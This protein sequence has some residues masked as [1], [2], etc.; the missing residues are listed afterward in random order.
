MIKVS[1]QIGTVVETTI[2]AV[3]TSAPP[4]FKPL[5]LSWRKEG[6]RQDARRA[7][8]RRQSA[9]Y[10]LG[11]ANSR[12]GKDGA[13]FA[14]VSE[15][16]TTHRQGAVQLD[17]NHRSQIALAGF[18]FHLGR[19]RGRPAFDRRRLLVRERIC[20]GACFARARE[21]EL[22]IFPAIAA[23]ANGNS[24]TNCH[25]FSGSMEQNCARC[26]NAE[27]FVATVIEPHAA[28]GIGCVV[29]SC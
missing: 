7:A 20:A 19:D 18:V 2:S 27:A 5:R 9:G 6:A 15:E 13:A 28:A 3:P 26:H 8:S 14:A 4:S 17:T 22:N 16:P 24:C 29:L 11:Q 12:S 21:I 23:K 1:L 25:S 10:F